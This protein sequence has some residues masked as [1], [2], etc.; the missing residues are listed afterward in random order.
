MSDESFRSLFLSSFLFLFRNIAGHGFAFLPL[1][2]CVTPMD[3]TSLG[4]STTRCPMSTTSQVPP[5]TTC[6]HRT[7][8]KPCGSPMSH[9]HASPLPQTTHKTLVP[10]T[11]L[12][13]PAKHQHLSP[14]RSSSPHPSPV[15]PSF[16]RPNSV[17]P[18]P[19][20]PNPTRCSS[21]QSALCPGPVACPSPARCSSPFI[22]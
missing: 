9:R 2:Q 13:S 10:T 12:A 11:C 3:A 22:Q 4:H 16:A 19:A 5:P 1:C 18:S 7:P 21:P 20:C 8:H 15:C 6:P 17:H 14:M